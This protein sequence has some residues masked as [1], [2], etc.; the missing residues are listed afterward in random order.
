M[1]REVPG[2]SASP[3]EKGA[4]AGAAFLTATSA[5]GPGFL[6]QT[7]VF[8]EQ[9]GRDFAFAILTS[10]VLALF[11]QQNA[12]RVLVASGR[13][14]PELASAVVPGLGPALAV[15]VFA[16]GLVFNVGNVA[17]CGLG[18]AVF[19]VPEAAGA[20]GSAL[21][22]ALVLARPRAGSAL[23][24]VSRVL[25]AVMIFATLAVAVASRP[26]A[27]GAAAAAVRPSA[28]AVLPVL[29]L[30]G[31]TVGGYIPFSGAHRLLD[32]G[33]AGPEATP[34]AARSAAL[35]VGVTAAMRVLFFLAVLGVVGHGSALD[36]ANPPA[37]AFRLGAGAWGYRLFGV[38][39]WSAALTSIVGCTYTSV[40][41]AE[42][43]WPRLARR[44]A[45]AV[46][47]F[48]AVSLAAFLALGRP[49]R[50]LVLAGAL[51]GLVL[52]ATLL[53]ALLA[54]R[55]GDLLG[56]YRNPRW[57]QAAGWATLVLATAAA[58]LGLREIARL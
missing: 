45:P 37:S 55:R 39:L 56:G 47:A 17:G 6:T 54:A 49:V 43:A 32:A 4:L 1:A 10:V 42:S 41:F 25:G 9:H 5:I 30:L 53:V 23:D 35:G 57:L 33:L 50:L 22:V 13:R 19:G 20:V 27:A 51:N 26:D 2:R 14:A 46:A 29:T 38:V 36:P 15:L 21:L 44:R 52:P 8:T 24:L 28:I 3:R 7:A 11:V 58:L 12:W 34:D 31:G 18:L 16:G 40:S 48:V